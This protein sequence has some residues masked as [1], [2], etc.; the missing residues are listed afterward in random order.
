MGDGARSEIA[1][2]HG[3]P[4]AL[5]RVVCPRI[6]IGDLAD[7]LRRAGRYHRFQ[8][9]GHSSVKLGAAALG[10]GVVDRVPQ[11][12]L[13]ERH[14]LA[15]RRLIE[16]PLLYERAHQQ[17]RLLRVLIEHAR[18]VFGLANLAEGGGGLQH[19]ALVVGEGLRLLHEDGRRPARNAQ[20][21][22]ALH[23][24]HPAARLPIH[25]SAGDEVVDHATDVE[26]R[27]T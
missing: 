3:V 16:E 4:D 2:L 18:E 10:H 7:V 20:R 15:I 1:R 11:V 14:T 19:R 9:A 12:H 23:L 13:R 22:D 6:V 8:D 5:L 26:R 21:A 17:V 27:A 24:G 25:E